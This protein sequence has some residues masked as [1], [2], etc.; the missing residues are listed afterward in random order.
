ACGGSAATSVVV[1]NATT[2]TCTSPAGVG[3]VDVTVTDAGGTSA[4]NAN[5]KFSYTPSVTNVSPN[6]GPAAG[7]TP[8]T[9][10]GTGFVSGATVAFG[11]N[12]ATSVVVMNA[13]TI[14]CTSPAGTVGTTVDVIVTDAGGTSAAN[15]NDKSTYNNAPTVTNVSP[16][17]GPA[18]GGTPVTLTGTGFV[19]GATVAFGGNA[20]TSV[21]VMNA[22]TITCTS[23][24]GV[25]QVDVI[26]TDAN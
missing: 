3:Q 24:A 17:S 21:V 19:S 4:A 22:T 12:A 10:T 5:D 9:L 25:G 14:T 7:G 1:M 23:P 18:A 11:G 26:V 2:I 13:T 20:A 15:A 6:S 16:N 8:V